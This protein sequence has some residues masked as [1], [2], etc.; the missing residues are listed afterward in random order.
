MEP[1]LDHMRRMLLLASLLRTDP[2]CVGKCVEHTNTACAHEHSILYANAWASVRREHSVRGQLRGAH[3]HSMP[4]VCNVH[5]IRAARTHRV[6][7]VCT[8]AC[9][10]HMQVRGGRDARSQ[11]R[12][13]R[14]ARVHTDP[15]GCG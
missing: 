5:C 13:C 15:R 10:L 2:T 4:A 8:L 3:E 6:C 1:R 9:T 11:R 7:A 12:A 14:G